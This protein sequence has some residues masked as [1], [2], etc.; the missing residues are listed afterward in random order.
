MLTVLSLGALFAPAH[1]DEGCLDPFVHSAV[2]KLPS[3][4]LT[5]DRGLL[6]LDGRLLAAEV[7]SVDVA[8]DHV[9][10]VQHRTD[11]MLRDLVAFDAA[12]AR[13]IPLTL[14]TTPSQPVLSDDGEQVVF[15]D[16]RTG[17]TALWMQSF[18]GG[19]ARQLTNVDVKRVVGQAPVG[20]VPSPDAG[21]LTWSGDT[22]TWTA[23]GERRTIELAVAGGAR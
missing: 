7:E 5:L 4:E 23:E 14:S 17:L 9:V 10:Y 3:G 19:R 22:L 11:G 21:D 2:W 1:A 18:S 20:F 13:S 15:V 8:G 12:D 6:Q 16:G